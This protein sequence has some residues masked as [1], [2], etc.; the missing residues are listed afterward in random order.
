MNL[1]ELAEFI[2]EAK[3]SAYAGDGN[4]VPPQRPGFKELEHSKGDYVYRDSYKGF[5]QA[6]GQEVV[7]YKG[8]P[9]W[10]M[11]YNGGMLEEY[12][13][14]VGFALKTFS[15]LKKALSEVNAEKPYRGPELLEENEW[16]YINNIKGSL[17]N[18]RG[19]EKIYFNKKLV[20]EQDYFGGLVI[21]K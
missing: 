10:I 18:F 8:E 9:V 3:K 17:T 11:S 4:E 12:Q 7:W 2:V 20:F 13:K 1:K 14:N 5:F 15:F 16:K 21:N 19:K 6:P